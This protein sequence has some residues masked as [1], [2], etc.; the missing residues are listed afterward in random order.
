MMRFLQGADRTVVF[1][2]TPTT[3]IE[4]EKL[5][6]FRRLLPS[7]GGIDLSQFPSLQPL[8]P[9]RGRDDDR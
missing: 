2:P 9:E 8:F 7:F 1:D 4:I 3:R 6:V 5:R